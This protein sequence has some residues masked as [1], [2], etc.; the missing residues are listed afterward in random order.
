M[1]N[2]DL[3]WCG[4]VFSRSVKCLPLVE[5]WRVYIGRWQTS[6]QVDL[7]QGHFIVGSH[8]QIEIDEWLL[9]KMIGQSRYC[10]AEGLQGPGNQLN[11]PHMVFAPG[12]PQK[13]WVRAKIHEIPRDWINS[14][15]DQTKIVSWNET[16]IFLP[17]DKPPVF[18]A[19]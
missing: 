7:V 12:G 6:D 13:T 17:V 10:L 19:R 3:G 1:K 16:N 18:H 4:E 5:K 2:I 11:I 14:S 9:Q 15:V 8:T